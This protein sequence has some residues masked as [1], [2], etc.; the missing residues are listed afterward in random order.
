MKRSALSLVILAVIVVAAAVLTRGAGFSTRRAPWWVEETAAR[1]ALRWA[2]P[3]AIRDQPNPVSPSTEALRAG[4]EHWAD[5]CATCHENDGSGDNE[6][7]RNLYPPAPDMRGP[8]TQQLTDG[9]LFYI[10]ENGVP[11]TGM[12]AWGTGTEDG[13]RQSWEL[14]LFVRHLPS[15]TTEELQRMEKLNPMSPA[16]EQQEKDIDDFLSGK[17]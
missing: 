8:R 11:F 12:P 6:L 16:K 9:E 1:N 10:I 17:N 15:V 3:A 7:G 5:H 4:M 14:V 13:E 2:I